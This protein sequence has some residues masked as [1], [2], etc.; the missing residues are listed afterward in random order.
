MFNRFS[1]PRIP[2]YTSLPVLE[3]LEEEIINEDFHPALWELSALKQA[4]M[5]E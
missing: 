4:H 5:T 2:V 1:Q 3:V